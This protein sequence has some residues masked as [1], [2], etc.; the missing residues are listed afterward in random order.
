MDFLEKLDFLMKREGYN[1]HSLAEA[2]GIPYTTIDGIYKRGYDRL[3]LPT[4]K[5]ISNFFGTTLDYWVLDDITDPDYGKYRTFEV[6]SQEREI[7]TK[8]RDM[9]VYGKDLVETVVEKEWKRVKESTTDVI[10]SSAEIIPIHYPTRLINYYYRMAS[11]GTGQIVFDEPPSKR[12][13]IPNTQKYKRVDYA[14]GVN[15]NSMEPA[16]SDGDILLIEMASEIDVG[17]TGIFCVSGESYVKELGDGELIS[18]NKDYDNIKLTP[19]ARCLGRVIGKLDL[20]A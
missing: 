9:D 6:N 18:L 11:A 5:R 19:D 16:Y 2:S 15:G 3:Q 4:I 20:E 7:V 13:E 8:Y 10:G 1:K 12:I 17:D 14:I